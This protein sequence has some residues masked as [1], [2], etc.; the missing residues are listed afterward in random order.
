MGSWFSSD[1]K[2]ENKV[3]KIKDTPSA[4][5]GDVLLEISDIEQSRMII[6]EPSFKGGAS[7]RKVSM[8]KLAID[9]VVTSDNYKIILSKDKALGKVKYAHFSIFMDADFIHWGENP[10]YNLNFYIKDGANGK[11]L[12]KVSQRLVLE[13]RLLYE[14][15]ILLYRLIYGENFVLTS[16]REKKL[17]VLKKKIAKV[18]AL[19]LDIEKIDEF[20]VELKKRRKISKLDNIKDEEKKSIKKKKLRIK[21]PISPPL[22]LPPGSSLKAQEAS[23]VDEEVEEQET[24]GFISKSKNKKQDEQ[25]QKPD[26]KKADVSKTK[27]EEMLTPE[28]ISAKLNKSLS[29]EILAIEEQEEQE[30]DDELKEAEKEEDKSKSKRKGK[31]VKSNIDAKDLKKIDELGSL[32]GVK[33]RKSYSVGLGVLVETIDSTDIISVTNNFKHFSVNAIGDI[34]FIEKNP[35][36]LKLN[37]KLTK[38]FDSGEFEIPGITQLGFLYL[39]RYGNSFIRPILGFD[40][41]TQTFV[42]LSYQGEGLQVNQNSLFWYKVGLLVDFE[43]LSKTIKFGS[44]LSKIWIG[45]TDYIGQGN[46]LTIDGNKIEAFFSMQIW[47]ETQLTYSIASERMTSP[48]LRNLVNVHTSSHFSFIYPIK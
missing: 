18:D 15:Q 27:S 24:P 22:I 13:R 10:G 37:L 8:L 11:T 23:T 35:T 34:K 14:S 17:A 1:I 28:A 12:R 16:E 26:I 21:I 42:N 3:A 4:K 40:Y 41:E 43:I 44:A 30:E 6:N 47:K 36:E 45:T 46:S 32:F 5:D 25:V 2:E 20:K 7:P 39:K 9:E 19:P 48:G 33:F 31:I 38:T 29:K